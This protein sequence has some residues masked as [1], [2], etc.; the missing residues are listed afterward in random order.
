MFDFW[1]ISVCVCLKLNCIPHLSV[2]LSVFFSV[3]VYVWFPVC[4]CLSYVKLRSP[5]VCPLVYL[6]VCLISSL[7]LSV[8]KLN[9]I[10][11]LSVCLSVCMFDFQCA[12]ACMHVTC[13]KL[14][15]PPV[16]LSVCLHV[17]LCICLIS[18]SWT[19][20]HYY[21]YY[22]DCN[23]EAHQALGRLTRLLGSISRPQTHTVQDSNTY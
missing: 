15:P 8:L 16:C 9:C 7:C 3:C 1:S 6:C 21:Y 10:H 11:H 20:N 2:C 13:L 5:P 14:H 4:V 19:N 17:Y 12:R 22:Y 23:G 18:C